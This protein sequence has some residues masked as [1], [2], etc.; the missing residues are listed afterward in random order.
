MNKLPDKKLLKL[1]IKHFNEFEKGVKKGH[2]PLGLSQRLTKKEWKLQSTNIESYASCFID[3]EKGALLN[4]FDD[5]KHVYKIIRY[6]R[7]KEEE[8]ELWKQI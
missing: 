7:I 6:E 4:Y 8:W 3:R 5:G 1:L 2:V